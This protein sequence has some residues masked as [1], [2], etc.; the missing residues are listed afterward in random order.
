VDDFIDAEQPRC[1]ECGVLM[2]DMPEG[3][4]CPSC[5]HSITADPLTG[6]MPHSDGRGVRGG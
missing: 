4:V 3:W 2:R 1:P 6:P 5:G